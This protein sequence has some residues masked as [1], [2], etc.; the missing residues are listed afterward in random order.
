VRGHGRERRLVGLRNIHGEGKRAGSTQVKATK[1]KER[2]EK[3][4]EM[5][6]R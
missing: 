6:L 2:R 5:I 3:A 1:E 4:K